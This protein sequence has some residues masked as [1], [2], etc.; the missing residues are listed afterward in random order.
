MLQS[1]WFV[2]RAAACLEDKEREQR[3]RNCPPAPQCCAA[4]SSAVPCSAVQRSAVPC[5]AVPRSA[6]YRIAS[7]HSA[8]R[9]VQCSAAQ[10]SAVPP[11]RC[12][13]RPPATVVCLRVQLGVHG[14]PA[15]HVGRNERGELARS[16]LR[17]QLRQF[18]LLRRSRA[19]RVHLHDRA[20]D[21]ATA[22]ALRIRA[23]RR[24]ACLPQPPSDSAHNSSAG[25][26]ALARPP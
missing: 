23:S 21:R 13:G 4:Q 7:H 17:L 8:A 15:A 25:F 26:S 2:V 1:A 10:R 20:V 16:V 5:S 24:S 18:G 14:L 3:E 6:A 9:P 11:C 22:H 19:A 12:R